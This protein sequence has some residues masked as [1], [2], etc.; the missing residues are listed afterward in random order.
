MPTEHDK[1][2]QTAALL[3]AVIEGLEKAD[4]KM[5]AE[6]KRNLMDV[7]DSI[8]KK[9]MSVAN[10]FIMDAHEIEDKGHASI[11]LCLASV[12]FT[13]HSLGMPLDVY[14]KMVE[15]MYVLSKKHIAELKVK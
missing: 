1:I 4:P 15:D 14:M 3:K 2:S 10:I 9:S 11:G 8:I 5:A 6:I 13:I 12:A 7:K